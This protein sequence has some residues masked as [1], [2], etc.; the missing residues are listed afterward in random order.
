MT[1]YNLLHLLSEADNTFII[2][3]PNYHSSSI[4]AEL[5]GSIVFQ[6]FTGVSRL[7]LISSVWRFALFNRQFDV[8]LC[9]SADSVAMFYLMTSS[10]QVRC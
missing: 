7:L 2:D 9:L 8:N 10:A 6:V 4:S 5:N 3:Q 1:H